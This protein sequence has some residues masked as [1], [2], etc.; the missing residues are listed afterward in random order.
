[1]DQEFVRKDF[2]ERF[3]PDIYKTLITRWVFVDCDETD[4][5]LPCYRVFLTF[6]NTFGGLCN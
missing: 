4:I 3:G 5:R 2:L 1:M 6:W